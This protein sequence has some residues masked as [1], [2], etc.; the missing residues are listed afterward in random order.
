MIKET[1]KTLNLNEEKIVEKIV[2]VGYEKD[3]IED[4]I[5][6]FE[7][8][9]FNPQVLINEIADDYVETN[10]KKVFDMFKDNFELQ[11]RTLNMSVPNG[12]VFDTM[13]MAQ[14]EY[15]QDILSEISTQLGW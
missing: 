14:Y 5:S 9:N 7:K 3:M 10:Y 6:D 11:N 4:F 8:T 12:T 13:Q 15:N 2:G 1:R